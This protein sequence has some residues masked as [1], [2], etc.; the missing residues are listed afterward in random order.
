M[1]ADGVERKVELG[2]N[3]RGGEK[4]AT[5]DPYDRVDLG[6][7]LRGKVMGLRDK[8]GRA[9]ELPFAIDVV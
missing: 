5:S 4:P 3:R 1:I 8:V 9:I 7:K 6:R 2:G